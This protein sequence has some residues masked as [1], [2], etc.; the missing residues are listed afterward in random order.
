MLH[1]ELDEV[2]GP[3]R[4]PELEDKKSL[5]YLEA[6]ITETQRISSLVSLALPHK[7]TVDTT[8]HGYDIP[9]GTTVLAN[10]WSLHHDPDIWEAPNDHRPQRFLDEEGNFVPPKA[11]IF[12]PF[13]GG[14]R[15]CVGK[16]LARIEFFL[17]LARSLH[18]FKFENPP[19]YDLP[20]LEPISSIALMPQPFH[21]CAFKR[22][23]V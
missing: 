23:A 4:L 3:H 19:G 8:L 1:Q 17:V 22:H 18:S 5:P 14:R 2:I 10:L 21:G 7:T 15:I 13:S 6:T 9:K 16:P 11:D 12:L 20:T